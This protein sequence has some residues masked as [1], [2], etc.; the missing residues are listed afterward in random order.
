[1]TSSSKRLLEELTQADGVSGHEQAVR[2]IFERRLKGV[3]PI[4][5]DRMG[6]VYCTV[7]GRSA[8]PRILLDCHLDEIGFIVQS[9]E[10]SGYLRFVAAGGW[11][12]HTL[13]AQRVTVHTPKGPIPG[14]IGSTPPHHL[15]EKARTQLLKIEELYIDVGASDL[16]EAVTIYGIA[17]G[18]PVAP[19]GPFTPMKNPKLLSAKAFDN[20][21]G[22]ALVI[23]AMRGLKNPPGTVIGAGCVQEEVGLRGARTIVASTKP[24]IA[25]VLEAPPADDTPG[26]EP[27]CM[28][29]RLGGGVQIRLFD[30]TMITHPRLAEFVLRVAEENEIP[31]QTAVRRRG[32]TDAGEIHKSARGVPAVVLGVPTRYIHSHVS[33]VNMDDYLAALDLIGKLIGRLDR[34]TVQGLF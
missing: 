20:R 33:I 30:P 14:V 29:G 13:P 17:P 34:K 1:M 23:E 21:L 6:N 12:S 8:S 4:G 3:G 18:C 15:G 5:R 10:P 32:G 25:L 22:V 24:D 19:Y 26:L 11:W 9:I 7:R 2:E 28:Q 27:H 16:E 31:H